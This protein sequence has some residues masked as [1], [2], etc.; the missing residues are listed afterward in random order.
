MMINDSLH[1]RINGY[2]KR[3]EN[4]YTLTGVDSGLSAEDFEL[5]AASMA[6]YQSAEPGQ[7]FLGVISLN[8]NANGKYDVHLIASANEGSG[9]PT[10]DKQ[11]KPWLK[12]KAKLGKGGHNI[13]L[14]AVMQL[15][16]AEQYTQGRLLGFGLWKSGS[17]V[18]FPDVLPDKNGLVPDEYHVQMV[19]GKFRVYYVNEALELALVKDE[20]L[21][22]LLQRQYARHGSNLQSD[23]TKYAL[24]DVIRNFHHIRQQGL[25]EKEQ[26]IQMIGLQFSGAAQASSSMAAAQ[27]SPVQIKHVRISST[28]LNDGSTPKLGGASGACVYDELYLKCAHAFM[29][30]QVTHA[31]QIARGLPLPVA[32]SLYEYLSMTLAETPVTYE[33]LIHVLPPAVRQDKALEAGFSEN[34]VY[35]LYIYARITG[36]IQLIQFLKAD[37]PEIKSSGDDLSHSLIDTAIKAAIPDVSNPDSEE[38]ASQFIASRVD[39]LHKLI[40]S[41]E[42]PDFMFTAVMLGLMFY[43]DREKKLDIFQGVMTRL[44]SMGADVAGH[45]DFRLLSL[46]AAAYLIKI[47]VSVQLIM[48]RL[49]RSVDFNANEPEKVLQFKQFFEQLLGLGANPANGLEVCNPAREWLVHYLLEKGADPGRG[50]LPNIA[51]RYAYMD[52]LSVVPISAYKDD[53]IPMS[54]AAKYG[55]VDVI[56]ALADMGMDPNLLDKQ[57]Q[58]PTMI[59][60]KNKK[61]ESV[62]ALRNAGAN[63]LQT[64]K[65]GHSLA[66]ETAIIGNLPMLQILIEAGA[67]INQPDSSGRSPLAAAARH[68]HEHILTWLE[69]NG[70]GA[71]SQEIHSSPEQPE[72]P[73]YKADFSMNK[74]VFFKSAQAQTK[75][76]IDYDNSLDKNNDNSMN[77][78]A[79]VRKK[80]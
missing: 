54:I 43:E 72:E 25:S 32:K 73:G 33:K 68:Y 1:D 55:H 60:V 42:N 11:G 30:E 53:D 29:L 24:I 10:T 9:A 70:F 62:L 40:D 48:E 15:G 19:D 16:L 79:I 18:M 38:I 31:N 66:V 39:I 23:K 65:D 22:L 35:S 5:T 34:P 12:S 7:S 61:W 49:L 36:D 57:G 37:Y 45:Y 8:K 51:A 41:G 69:L 52:L 14:Q 59:A 78:G 20:L 47:G 80:S 50:S 63:L 28:S 64:D 26:K 2:L 58:L 76:S 3:I 44:V 56:R 21:E 77:Q 75:P 4:Y 74:R 27:E 13:H 67:D 6:H 46:D 17:A 71:H